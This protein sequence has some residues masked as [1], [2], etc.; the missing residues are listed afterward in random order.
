MTRPPTSVSLAPISG[1]NVPPL[2]SI[3]PHNYNSQGTQWKPNDSSLLK[4]D[5]TK[6]FQ[7]FNRK[8]FC[9]SQ[10]LMSVISIICFSIQVQLKASKFFASHYGTKWLLNDVMRLKRKKEKERKTERREW[11]REGGRNQ[12]L[13]AIG[14][15]SHTADTVNYCY[16]TVGTLSCNKQPHHSK[17]KQGSTF[18]AQQRYD[19]HFT[20]RKWE[21]KGSLTLLMKES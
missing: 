20:S 19:N 9:S 14:S 1:K 8:Q 5:W 11:G 15:C 10:A 6:Y 18:Q 12:H 21:N 2:S 7:I 13:L 16:H 3:R 17:Q 4:L